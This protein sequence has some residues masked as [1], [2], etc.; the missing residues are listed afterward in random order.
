MIVPSLFLLHSSHMVVQYHVT[1]I[2]QSRNN[3]GF[4]APTSNWFVTTISNKTVNYI[5]ASNQYR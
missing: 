3:H 2:I 4:E 5:S 1:I